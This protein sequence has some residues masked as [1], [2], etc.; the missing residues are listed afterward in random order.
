M[1]E[2]DVTLKGLT[3]AFANGRPDQLLVTMAVSERIEDG[4]SEIYPMP[5]VVTVSLEPYRMIIPLNDKHALITWGSQVEFHIT[6][7]EDE[8][9]AEFVWAKE[10]SK[11]FTLKE[12]LV[13]PAP[14]E[15]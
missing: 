6:G 11:T 3:L 8:P 15:E 4:K 5:K 2:L 13:T 9:K 7:T 12:F 14:S 1:K 10:R